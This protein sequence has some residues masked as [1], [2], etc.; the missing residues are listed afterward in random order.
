MQT[1]YTLLYRYV[2]PNTNTPI[3]GSAPYEKTEELYSDDHKLNI[4]KAAIDTLQNGGYSLKGLFDG[5]TS[6]DFADALN[7]EATEEREELIRNNMT[8]EDKSNNLFIYTGTKK[9]FHQQYIPEQLGY[10]VRDWTRVPKDQIPNGPDDFS[11]HF[12]MLGG[13]RLGYDNA[14]LVC[15]PQYIKT[16]MKKNTGVDKNSKNLTNQPCFLNIS[17]NDQNNLGYKKNSE[18]YRTQNVYIPNLKAIIDDATFFKWYEFDSDEEIRYGERMASA[19]FT[20]NVPVSSSGSNAQDYAP[21]TNSWSTS[22]SGS[23]PSVRYYYI[24]FNKENGNT[25]PTGL[26]ETQFSPGNN[27]AQRG[28]LWN[29]I[30]NKHYDTFGNYLIV[31]ETNIIRDTIPAHYE[32]TGSHPYYIKDQYQKIELSPWILHS[33]H[34]SLESSLTSA[35][36]LVSMIGIENVKLIKHV[37]IEQFIKIK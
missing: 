21:T 16:Y 32:D 20:V 2:N 19:F 7:A 9:V 25:P 13:I 28:I 14:Y 31:D 26:N 3:T 6:Q 35:K 1:Q 18:Y 29:N 27:Q 37:P 12:V 22:G 36:K 10:V 24:Y 17:T 5:T 34:N 8:N 30:Q 15:K 33:V 11:K 4:S 23:G